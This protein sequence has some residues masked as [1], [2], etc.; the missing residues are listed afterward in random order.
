MSLT[1][2]TAPPTDPGPA[3]TRRRRAGRSRLEP[4]N[5]WAGLLTVGW[6]TIVAVPLL[7]MIN[8]SLQSQDAYLADGPLAPPR[9]IT[10]DN[11]VTVFDSGFLLFFLNTAVVTVACVGLTL[12]VAVP[13]A[14]AI[15]RSPSRIVA[16][17]FRGFLLGLAIP[18]QATIIPIYLLIVRMGLYDTLGAIILPTTAFSLPLAVLV[19]ASALRDVPREQYEAMT[20]DGASAWR[21]MFS[22]A[23]PMSLGS[24]IT[25]GVYTALTAWNGFLFPLILTQSVDQRVLTLGLWSFQSEFGVDVPGLMTAV[26]LSAMPVFLAYLLAR[27]WLIAGLA[28][29]GGK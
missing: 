18:A 1:T 4:P 19:L 13:A 28:G 9:A 12:I 2:A 21:M 23:V 11:L 26:L 6:L 29:V 24:V 15:V 27:R 10:A 3:E 16:A 5:R 17:G 25:V 20:L 7:V 8:W 22:L 14:Y